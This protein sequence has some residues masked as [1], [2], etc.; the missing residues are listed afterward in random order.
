ME[1]LTN[2]GP[3]SPLGD[4]NPALKVVFILEKASLQVVH[5]DDYPLRHMDFF[6]T[7]RG[8]YV[9]IVMRS[10]ELWNVSEQI[11]CNNV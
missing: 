5:S 11:E 6:V 8:F 7:A 9:C 4:L 10:Y 1:G 3:G 2:L